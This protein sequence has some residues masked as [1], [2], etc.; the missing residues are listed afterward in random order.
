MTLD[1]ALL[2]VRAAIEQ[3]GGS[4]TGV[5]IVVADRDTMLAV[6][7]ALGGLA[8]ALPDNHKFTVLGFQFELEKLVGEK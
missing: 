1:H 6:H 7:R 2:E 3:A 8:F 4:V 5:K